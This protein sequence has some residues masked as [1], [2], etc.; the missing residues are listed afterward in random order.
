MRV[1]SYSSYVNDCEA[2]V[3]VAAGSK[4]AAFSEGAV[5][6]LTGMGF[7]RD[8]AERAL[9]VTHGSADR[10]AAWLADQMT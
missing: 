1:H 7:S 10:A 2:A 6:A 3:S 5:G 8:Q 4:T 9:W